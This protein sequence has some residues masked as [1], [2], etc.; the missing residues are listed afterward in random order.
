MGFDQ[1]KDKAQ[2]ALGRHGDKAEQGVDKA[3][4]LADEK[5][6][7]RYSDQLEQGADRLKDRMGE[8]RQ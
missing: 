6:G 8:Q 7:G 2:E 4:E 1:M 5:T 3:R